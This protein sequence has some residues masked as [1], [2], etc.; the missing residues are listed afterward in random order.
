[1]KQVKYLKHSLVI[2]AALGLSGCSIFGDEELSYKELQ[3]FN[4]SV[5]PSVQWDAGAGDGIG[6]FFSRL[7]PTVVGDHVV[8]ADRQ[9]MIMAFNRANGNRVWERDLQAQFA[10]Q[11][12][13]WLDGAE[14][15][16]ISGGLVSYGDNV[17]LGTEN[18][19]VIMLNGV[20][21]SVLW[22]TNIKA[23]VVSDP[24]LDANHVVI[25]ASNGKVVGLNAETG[26]E[27]WSMVTDVPALSLRG[28]GAPTLASGGA[29]FGTANGKLT[30]AVLD[31]GQQVWEARLAIPKGATE[32]QRLVDVDAA[33]ISRGELIYNIAY[34]GQLAAVEMRTGR[35]VWQR[36][37]SSFQN[38]DMY[39]Q[40]IYATD[41]DDRVYAINVD[42]GIERWVNADFEGRELTAPVYYNGSIVVGDSFGYL[43]FI[44][45]ASGETEGRLEVGSD[46]YVA[47]VV[48]DNELYIQTR[49]GTLLAVRT[50]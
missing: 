50:N 4:A 5:Q 23:E 26:E 42:G 11:G 2:A 40:T 47:P 41:A 36:E 49:D 30:V 12:E 37:Y 8:V 20:D 43:H 44:D 6:E 18:G 9:G 33:P 39:G 21:G 48:A 22:H 27:R 15:L 1:M 28:T 46:V 3:P 34:N 17:V 32:L 24:A 38:L 31:N 14:S 10:A 7:N 29:I 13:G 19:D 35:V 45:A 25:T 16:R